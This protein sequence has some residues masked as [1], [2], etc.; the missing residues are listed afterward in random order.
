V[1]A[2]ADAEDAVDG[3]A[4][5]DVGRLL[6]MEEQWEARHHRRIGKEEVRGN[7]GG[8]HSGGH[9]EDDDNASTCLGGS[10]GAAGCHRAR[11]YNCNKRGHI[12]KFCPE[13]A[14]MVMMTEVNEESALL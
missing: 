12:A 9:G 13:H 1:A 3:V 5:D 7:K 8:G 10:R 4:A 2:V 11:C 14:K 6:L